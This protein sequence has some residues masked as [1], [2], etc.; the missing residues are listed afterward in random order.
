M[1]V[2]EPLAVPTNGIGE[3][4]TLV[5]Y[6]LFP[7]TGFWPIVKVL[8]AVMVFPFSPSPSVPETR[9]SVP[10]VVNVIVCA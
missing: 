2:P 6:T 4:V 8:V 7:E 9:F 5:A 3:T 1:T 10:E